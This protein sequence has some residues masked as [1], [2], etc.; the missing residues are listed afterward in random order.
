M[1]AVT[2]YSDFLEH[3]PNGKADRLNIF[4]CTDSMVTDEEAEEY[5]YLDQGDRFQCEGFILHPRKLWAIPVELVLDNPNEV[6]LV[7]SVIESSQAPLAARQADAV[8]LSDP[9]HRRTFPLGSRKN[10]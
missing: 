6:D 3:F 8:K 7:L 5:G 2:E 10:G 1:E 9:D 4:V